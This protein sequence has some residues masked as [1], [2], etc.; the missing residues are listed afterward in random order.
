LPSSAATDDNAVMET[1]QPEPKRRRY[2]FSLSTLLVV[3]MLLCVV[4]WLARHLSVK[5][6]ESVWQQVLMNDIF[7][8]PLQDAS[9]N[10]AFV[11]AETN[12]IIVMTVP[13]PSIIV[14]PLRNDAQGRPSIA[15]GE[16]PNAI[17]LPFIKNVLL[18]RLPNGKERQFPLAAGSAATFANQYR[19]P[20]LGPEKSLLQK[21]VNLFGDAAQRSKVEQFLGGFRG[22]DAQQLQ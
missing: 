8:A 14:S 2:Q 17:D 4:A 20:E 1:E 13:R 10:T 19:G 9:G 15:W 7:P 18:I 16:P 5:F 3:A 11:C 22:Q 6:R 12:S 21:A